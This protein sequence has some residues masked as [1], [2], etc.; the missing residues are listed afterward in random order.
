MMADE[1]DVINNNEEGQ[2]DG[3][4]E[5]ASEAGSNERVPGDE[6]TNNNDDKAK[7]SSSVTETSELDGDEFGDDDDDGSE[8]P[9]LKYSRIEGSLPRTASSDLTQESQVDALRAKC[10]CS[11]MG[12]VTISPF[13]QTE[14]SLVTAG[15][16]LSSSTHGT[17]AAANESKLMQD[18]PYFSTRIQTFYILALAMEDGT[19]HLIDH[20]TGWHICQPK[21]MKVHSGTNQQDNIVALSFDA[22][23]TYLA[24]VTAE[25]DVAIFGFKFGITIGSGEGS[26]TGEKATSTSGGEERA[27][28]KVF[29]SFLSSIAGD[30]W[31]TSESGK[32]EKESLNKSKHKEDAA[33]ESSAKNTSRKNTVLPS[34]PMLQVTHPVSTA[35][36]SHKLSNSNSTKAT[37]ISL[38]PSYKRKRDKCVIVGFSNGRLIYT[39]R[40]GHRGSVADSGGFGGVMGN[41]LQPSRH[42][43]DLFQSVAPAGLKSEYHGIEYITWRGTL[44]S[45]ADAR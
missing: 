45:W 6:T 19:I 4:K 28:L 17:S 14:S 2:V 13:D 12:R 8:M 22:S 34:L 32:K 31:S 43:V 41:L 24:A 1:E 44:V 10:V 3:L 25:G 7:V 42:D 15:L 33:T 27:G 38:D 5:E 39:K 23:G 11:T 21:Q 36:F 37:C 29:D 20:R 18:D 16:G 9:L 35:R 30:D 26:V 40:N